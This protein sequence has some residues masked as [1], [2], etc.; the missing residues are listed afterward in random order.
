MR[1]KILAP[2]RGI[3]YSPAEEPKNLSERVQMEVGFDK[4]DGSERC[5]M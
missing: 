5:L 3:F 2:P 4:E 1:M